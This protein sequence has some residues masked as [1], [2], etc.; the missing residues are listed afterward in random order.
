VSRCQTAATTEH[1]FSTMPWPAVLRIDS[2]GPH[3]D[4]LMSLYGITT[5]PALVLLDGTGAVVCQDGRA[6][7]VNRQAGRGSTPTNPWQPFPDCDLPAAARQRPTG[8]HLPPD[9][10]FDLRRAARP[11]GVPP[12]FNETARDSQAMASRVGRQP[13][14]P[15]DASE[16]RKASTRTNVD[17]SAN[18]ASSLQ[19]PK[20]G[21]KKQLPPKPNLP[22]GQVPPKRPK[23]TFLSAA[24]T[25]TRTEP[26]LQRRS[27][28]SSWT[29]YNRTSAQLVLMASATEAAATTARPYTSATPRTQ[30]RQVR[31]ESPPHVASG[32]AWRL[33]QQEAQSQDSYL[34]KGNY[35]ARLWT[36]LRKVSLDH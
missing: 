19:P 28:A 12:A 14:P 11:P 2:V 10:R 32:A 20:K 4:S 36:N 26:S 33:A 9:P 31:G 29:S 35:E 15:P 23:V 16:R 1:L 13:T 21:S 6:K 8:V 18:A 25:L 3:G 22:Q 7:V 27:Q 17:T 24:S 30:Q 5:L 34:S